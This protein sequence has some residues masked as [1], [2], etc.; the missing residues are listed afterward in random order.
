MVSILRSKYFPNN[1]KKITWGVFKYYNKEDMI[2]SSYQIYNVF[3]SIDFIHKEE[4]F[5]LKACLPKD[6]ISNPSPANSN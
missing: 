1:K 6:K 2:P 5:F 3:N 4:D